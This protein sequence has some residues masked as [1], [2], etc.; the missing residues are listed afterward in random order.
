MGLADLCGYLGTR[1]EN[2]DKSDA[3]ECRKQPEGPIL[4]LV[5]GNGTVTVTGMLVADL[6]N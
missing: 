4:S 2:R 1:A 6:N 3:R 5:G